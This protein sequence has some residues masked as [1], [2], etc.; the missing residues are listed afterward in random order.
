[1]RLKGKIAVIERGAQGIGRQVAFS[2]ANEKARAIVGDIN[3]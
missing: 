3:E 2:M 1:M